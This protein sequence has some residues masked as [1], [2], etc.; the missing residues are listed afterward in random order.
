MVCSSLIEQPVHQPVELDAPDLHALVRWKGVGR[1][2][3][4][5]T[6]YGQVEEREVQTE[7][8]F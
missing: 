3:S 5:A 7:A 1:W 6:P 8:Q 2:T 4:R